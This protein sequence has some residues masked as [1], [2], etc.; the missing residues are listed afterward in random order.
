[1]QKHQ[2]GEVGNKIT[3]SSYISSGIFLPKTIKIELCLTKLRLLKD[4][5][6]FLT[7][8]VAYIYSTQHFFQLTGTLFMS[9]KKQLRKLKSLRNK[10]TGILS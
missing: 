4:G 3:P 6:V 9:Y 8:G 10:R 2:L 7:H 5:D 1:V